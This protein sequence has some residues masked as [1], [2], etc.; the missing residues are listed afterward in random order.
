M[1]QKLTALITIFEDRPYMT[2]L[3]EKIAVIKKVQKEYNYYPA[4]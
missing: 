2:M 3:K 1:G 4:N